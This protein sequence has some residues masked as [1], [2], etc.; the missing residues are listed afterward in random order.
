MQTIQDVVDMKVTKNRFGDLF[1]RQKAYFHT[2]VTK[3]YEW[4]IDQLNRLVSEADGL[5][6]LCQ[7]VVELVRRTGAEPSKRGEPHPVGGLV[8]DPP[9]VPAQ[10]RVLMPEHQQLSILG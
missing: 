1:D 2:N 10:H 4:R 5:E 9:G 6:R 3:S 8:P 7:L